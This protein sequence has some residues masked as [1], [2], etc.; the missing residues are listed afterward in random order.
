MLHLTI[1]AFFFN[2]KTDYL[3]YYKNFSISLAK[4]ATAKDLLI[5]IQAK[6]ENFSFPTEQP[7]NKL[8]FRV[9]QLVVEANESIENIVSKLGTELQ[10]DPVNSYRSNNGLIINDDD[11]MQSFELLAPFASEEDKAYYQTLYSLHYASE[12]SQFERQYIGDAI[13]VLAHK[14]I[15]DGNENEEAILKAITHPHSSLFDC[16]YENNLFNAQ[17]HSEAI[18]ALKRLIKPEKGRSP[19]AFLMSIFSKP[20]KEA[21]ENE[22]IQNNRKAILIEDL[23]DK[24]ISF[25]GKSVE[26]SQRVFNISR[27]HKLAGLGIIDDN[28][29]LAL[30]KAGAILLEA[31]DAGVEV[32]VVEDIAILDMFLKHFKEIESTIGRKMIGLELMST[33]DFVAQMHH[34]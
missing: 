30:H 16:E 1:K 32:L 2:A 11:F 9:N 33:D 20:K 24:T 21:S 14:M 15:T 22:M 12:T 6:N 18:T 5:A 3:P 19:L 26:A 4:T 28:R 17:D 10:I 31:Y 29:T 7:D 34:I 25:Y 23:E 8:V 27:A 13:L